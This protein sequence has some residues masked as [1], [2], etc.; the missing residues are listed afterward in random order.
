MQNNQGNGSSHL[1]DSYQGFI[2]TWEQWDVE[3][4]PPLGIRP[5]FMLMNFNMVVRLHIWLEVLC[6]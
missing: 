6:F 3:G 5:I 2:S 4:Q 1:G